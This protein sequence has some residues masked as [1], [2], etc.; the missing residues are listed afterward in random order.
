MHFK[1]STTAI[2]VVR[3]RIKPMY[4]LRIIKFPSPY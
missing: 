2:G 4:E 1:A 3:V